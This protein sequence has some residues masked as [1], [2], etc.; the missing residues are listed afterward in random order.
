[1][2]PPPPLPSPP[3]PLRLIRKVHARK[4]Y[5]VIHVVGD[6]IFLAYF[7]DSRFQPVKFGEA[8]TKTPNYSCIAL[9][10]TTI[11]ATYS[12][13]IQTRFVPDQM[14]NPVKLKLVLP[15]A[16]FLMRT[17]LYVYRAA[18]DTV[19]PP[20]PSTC[21]LLM[22]QKCIFV[23]HSLMEICCRFVFFPFNCFC[24]SYRI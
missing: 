14:N 22:N 2:P 8:E 20:R 13:L 23:S 4:I 17:S 15:F 10:P 19:T 3:L 11:E 6:K 7:D 9:F 1:M 5:R 16:I 21:N 12:I 18:T 24:S